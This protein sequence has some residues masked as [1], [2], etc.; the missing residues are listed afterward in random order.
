MPV[1]IDRG[2]RQG[3]D[4]PGPDALW[5]QPSIGPAHRPGFYTGI[6]VVREAP[7]KV[8]LALDVQSGSQ[9]PGQIESPQERLDDDCRPNCGR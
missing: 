3:T 5:H 6:G 7:S 9:R 8:D 4:L 2:F 1:R